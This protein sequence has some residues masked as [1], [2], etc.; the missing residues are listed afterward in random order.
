MKLKV[1]IREEEEAKRGIER[2]GKPRVSLKKKKKQREGL[3]LERDRNKVLWN[4]MIFGNLKNEKLDE[5][6]CL[7]GQMVRYAVVPTEFTYLRIL[8]A[9]GKLGDCSRGQVIHARVIVLHSCGDTKNGFNVFNKIESLNLVSWN[10]MISGYAR[11]GEGEDAMNMLIQLVGMS[12]SKPDEYT[13][14]AVISTTGAI[15]EFLMGN[16]FTLGMRRRKDLDDSVMLYSIEK[17]RPDGK[18]LTPK[19]R[20][21]IF[22][23][24]VERCFNLRTD[25]HPMEIFRLRISGNYDSSRVSAWISSAVRASVGEMLIISKETELSLSS[26]E[27][28]VVLKVSCYRIAFHVHPTILCFPRLKVLHLCCVF[29]MHDDACIERALLGSP[30]LEELKIEMEGRSRKRLM[31]QFL[32]ADDHLEEVDLPVHRI[33]T[34]ETPNI[35]LL[36]FADFASEELRISQWVQSL[37]EATVSQGRVTVLTKEPG[38]Y[39]D[40]VV[41]FFERISDVENLVLSDLAMKTLKDADKLGLPTFWDLTR[42][43]LKLDY[44]TETSHQWRDPGINLLPHCLPSCLEVIELKDFTGQS[45]EM[46]MVE[47]F[48]RNAEVLMKMAIRYEKGIDNSKEVVVERLSNCRKG[49][50]H[51]YQIEFLP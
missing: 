25:A 29:P 37:V 44:D 41:G 3:Y 19:E 11:N 39:A 24:F 40:M 43:E 48:L 21:A 18:F 35:K 26:C 13:F 22:G 30:V 31:M 15:P 14:V 6:V 9:C 36:K 45:E 42:L 49:S 23:D 2:F 47:Y 33:L 51:A 17:P 32:P 12:T 16:L 34:I 8:N 1:S 28:L 50:K 4:S 10:S 27:T 20:Q 7:F 46:K 38:D 5:R